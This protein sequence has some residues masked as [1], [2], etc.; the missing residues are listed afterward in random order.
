MVWKVEKN[1][2]PLV[3]NISSA[4]NIEI[5]ILLLQVYENDDGVRG[6]VLLLLL[7]FDVTGC[8]SFGGCE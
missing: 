4:L 1:I 5:F 8:Q 7:L 6:G 2:L 3:D